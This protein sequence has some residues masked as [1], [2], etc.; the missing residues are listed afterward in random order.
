M[1]EF[2]QEA[3]PLASLVV[4]GLRDAPLLL[5]CLQSLAAN[6]AGVSYEVIVVLNDP[7]PRLQAAIGEAVG[8][9]RVLTYSANLGFGAAV[10]QAAPVAR[11][12]YLALLND[13]CTVASGWLE[14]LVD[15]ARRRPRCGVVGSKA[16]NT[17]GS[18]QESGAIVW[19]DGTTMLVDEGTSLPFVDVE[20]RVDYCSAVS[21]LVRRSVW[22]Q[23]GGFDESYYPAYYEDVDLCFRAFNSGWEVWHQPRSVVFHAHSSS[24]AELER[25]FY[26][27]RSYG[28]FVERWPERLAQQATPGNV[29]NA[30]RLAMDRLPPAEGTATSAPPSPAT[31]G[32]PCA[33]PS[34]GGDGE[35]RRLVET[36]AM[37][38]ELGVRLALSS[39]LEQRVVEQQEHSDL[40]ER[41]IAAQESKLAACQD[42]VE[43][44]TRMLDTERRQAAEEQARAAQDLQLADNALAAERQQCATVVAA[45]HEA[46]ETLA[47]ERRRASYLMVQRLTER[48]GR[49]PAL[50]GW[51]KRVGARIVSR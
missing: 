7:T 29:Q 5:G 40:Q 23:V 46:Q 35:T 38:R 15:T 28:L 3:N 33:E 26:L 2:R 11:G 9:A 42:H 36:R 31:E 13:D 4:V 51:V 37:R 22:D 25:N 48:I 8:G 6:V 24:T 50:A 45:L 19:A 39:A 43:H 30:M 17:D 14:A 41:H 49:H 12:E 18:L 10:N 47:A 32:D 20:R 34:V 21:M 16:L 1:M 44:L 27:H